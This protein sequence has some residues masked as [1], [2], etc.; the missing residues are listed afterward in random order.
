M[1]VA[2]KGL[3]V[4]IITL[5]LLLSII[6]SGLLAQKNSRVEALA[7]RLEESGKKARQ[8][9]LAST[10]AYHDSLSKLLIP[11]RERQDLVAKEVLQYEQMYKEGLIQKHAVEPRKIELES[12]VKK[13]K[14]TEER[15][16]ESNKF[17]REIEAMLD[18]TAIA[19]QMI[20]E[21]DAEEKAVRRE[22]AAARRRPRI[23]VVGIFIIEDYGRTK[24]RV[25]KRR[26]Q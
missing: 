6:P 21:E 12:I 3:P 13:I 10:I 14:D 1:L 2:V 7:K 24:P 20:A 18:Y 23:Y 22:R 16:Q 4:K 25:F 9:L 8:D 26:N 11:L 5:V 19:K 15:I 17:I